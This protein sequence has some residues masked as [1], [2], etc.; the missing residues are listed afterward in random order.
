MQNEFG[1]NW[2][3]EKLDTLQR[4]LTSYTSVFKNKSFRLIYI[5]AFAGSGS[6]S[7]THQEEQDED[8]QSFVIGSPQRALEIK[9]RAF[10]R[11]IFVEKSTD[12]YRQLDELRTQNSD[13]DVQVIN[14]DAN[15][16]LETLIIDQS[17]WRGVVFLD[18]FATEVRWA[19][20][21]RI[22]GFCALDTWIL[23]PVSAIARMLPI[24]RKPD[25][26]S[27]AWALRLTEIFGDESWRDLYSQSAQLSFFDDERVERDPGIEGIVTVYKKKLKNLFGDRFLDESMTLRNSRNSPLFEFF[28]CVGNPSGIGPAKRIAKHLMRMGER[29][30]GNS[31]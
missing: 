29:S 12:R 30:H 14:F 20:L 23:F 16:F 11:L 7:L 9:D 21:E 8:F 17:Q 6:I 25:D 27:E 19:T 28:F 5:D 31:F 2:T 15:Q 24:S 10:D 13:R 22:A 26:I 1:G 4:Y 18:P 3:L